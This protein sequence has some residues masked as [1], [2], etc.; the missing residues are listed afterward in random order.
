MTDAVGEAVLQ[1]ARDAAAQ[2]DQRAA[3]ELFMQAD[4]LGLAGPGD[5]AVL[6][7]VAYAAGQLEVTIEAWERAYTLCL[8]AGDKDAAAGAAVRLAMHMLFDT[9][10]MA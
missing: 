3:F 2:G 5:L 10:L 7:E 8:R 1:R 9:A 4:T 6:A